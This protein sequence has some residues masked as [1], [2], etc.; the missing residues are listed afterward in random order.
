MS[1]IIGGIN[2]VLEALRARG[3]AVLRLYLA[4]G[5][6][7]READEILKLARHH[8]VR[9]ERVERVRLDRLYGPKGHQGVVAEVGPFPYQDLEDVIEAAGTGPSLLL[10]LDGVEDPMNLGALIRSAEA[11]G[12]GGVILP[13]EKAAPISAQAIKASAGAAEHLPAARVVNLV[14]TLERL[15]AAGYW[16][17]GAHGPAETSLYQADLDLPRMALVV[18]GEGR[19]I[20]R[21]VMEQCDLLVSIPLRGRVSSLNASVAGA[22]IMFEYLRRNIGRSDREKEG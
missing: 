6:A 21:L 13:R 17:V 8:G 14:R 15:K 1:E 22:L 18:G 9:V 10:V 20:R 5:R 11:A 19:G 3:S 16:V 12:A 7:G 2:P 4:Q